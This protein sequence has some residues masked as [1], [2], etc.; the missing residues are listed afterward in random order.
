[1]SKRPP[2]LSKPDLKQS[3]KKKKCT[4]VELQVASKSCWTGLL[5]CHQCH[6]IPQRYEKDHE[7]SWSLELFCDNFQTSFKICTFCPNNTK[8]FHTNEQLRKHR[9]LKSHVNNVKRETT[10]TP[11][12]THGGNYQFEDSAD[13]TETESSQFSI[14]EDALVFLQEKN[15]QYFIHQSCNQGMKYL[16]AI[17][18]F[19]DDETSRTKVSDSD[20]ELN[21]LLGNFVYNLSPSM[22]SSF[23]EI[24]Q[25]LK[26]SMLPCV[27]TIP[28]PYSLRIPF[29]PSTLR[30]NYLE[31]RHSLLANIP[32][33]PISSHYSGKNNVSLHSYCSFMD[34]LIHFLAFGNGVKNLHGKDDS[35]LGTDVNNLSDTWASNNIRISVL[36]KIIKTSEDIP[37][38]FTYVTTFSD[39]F[40]PTV[41]LVKANRHGVWVYQI[42]FF[43][44]QGQ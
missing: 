2:T 27:E 41:S 33:A 12:V 9:Y 32:P 10:E 31:G 23:L 19:P 21:I 25:K 34:C 44:K 26:S 16:L 40:D 8:Q 7:F 35:G 39:A 5:V 42:C 29:L 15:L 4:Y 3:S 14:N 6:D 11:I 24:V 28:D 30:K 18:Y 17:S 13:Y 37:V 20:S 22:R 1:M 43:K 38:V 36:E